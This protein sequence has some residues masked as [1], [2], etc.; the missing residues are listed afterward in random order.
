[1]GSALALDVDERDSG[2]DALVVEAREQVVSQVARLP[3][4]NDPMVIDPWYWQ[5][6]VTYDMPEVPSV[7]DVIP[8]EVDVGEPVLDV[9]MAVSRRGLGQEG[10][11]EGI[12]ELNY[13]YTN[14]PRQDKTGLIIFILLYLFI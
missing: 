12:Q 7:N 4:H 1:L 11:D 2:A 9:V 8:M 5:G 6:I 10:Y 13:K 3:E 14:S